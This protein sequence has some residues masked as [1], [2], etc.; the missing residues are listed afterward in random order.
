VRTSTLKKTLLNKAL[1][2]RTRLLKTV[3]TKTAIVACLALVGT[4]IGAVD[5]AVSARPLTKAP[6]V[7]VE[8]SIGGKDFA[9]RREAR[10]DPAMAS[11][12]SHHAHAE[13]P[14]PTSRLH[15]VLPSTGDG[16]TKVTGSPV[17]L[18]ALKA[19]AAESGVQPANDVGSADVEILPQTAARAAGVHGFIF[20]LSL[21]SSPISGAS[22]DPSPAA[23]GHST[24][25]ATAPTASPTD[26]AARTAPPSQS[27]T[28]DSTVQARA[29]VPVQVDYS[30]FAD[31]YGGDYASRLRLVVLPECA[32]ATPR[33]A[34]CPAPTPLATTRDAKTQTLR[35]T[36][37]V[38][39]SAADSATTT[40]GGATLL[41]VTST[42]GGDE[43]DFAATSLAPASEWSVGTQTGNFS[44]SYP[45][46]TVPV[47]GGL[48]PSVSVSYSSQ[49]IDGRTQASN[50]Q[51]SWLGEG[52]S[53]EP[54]YIERSYAACAD[55]QPAGEKTGD[56]CWKSANQNATM[57]FQGQSTQ[58]V[59]DKTTGEWRAKDDQGW[60]IRKLSDAPN[61]D[62]NGEYWEL[63]DQDGTRYYF[64]REKRFDADTELTRSAWTVPVY[65]DDPGE[66]CHASTFGQSR[67]AQVWRWNLDYVVDAHDN[68]IS[69]FYN[70]ET[71]RYGANLNNAQPSYV[72][73]GYLTRIDYGTV[74][75]Y[76]NSVLPA[77]RVA[78]TVAERCLPDADFDCDPS[79][80]N[81]TNAS[82]WPDVP[83]DQICTSDT[84]CP[85]VLSPTFF[86]RKRLVAVTTQVLSGGTFANVDQFDLTQSFPVAGD[87]S[88][89]SLYLNSIQRTGMNGG[90]ATT[91]P[92][93]FTAALMENRVMT[94]NTAPLNK[95]RVTG[96]TTETGSTITVNYSAKDCA[97]GDVPAE[98][99]TNTRRC[100]PV[101]YSLFGGDPTVNWFHKYVVDSVSEG[102]RA[103]TV[104]IS[105][106]YYTYSGGGAWHY[107]NNELV[108]KKYRTWGQ[109]R[110]YNTVE[111]RQGDPG[112]ADT[113]QSYDKYLYLRGMDGDQLPGGGTRS[114]T[115]TDS[116]GGTV[117]D[118]DRYNGFL[119][120]HIQKSGTTIVRAEINDPWSSDITANDSSDQAYIVRTGA[121]HVRKQFV[122]TPDLVK[123]TT[124]TDF[125]G[126]GLPT[127]VHDD[128]NDNDPND[129]TC[130][131]T[132]YAQN[133]AAWILTPVAKV[134]TVKVA[135]ST[136]VGSGDV[137]ASKRY[138][139]DNQPYSDTA[140][141]TRGEVTTEETL[142]GTGAGNWTV[143]KRSAYD[144]RGRAVTTTD[145]LG[146]T[147]A[148]AY[149]PAGTSAS[150]LGPVTATTS[151]NAKGQTSSTTLDPARGSAL[152]YTDLNGRVTSATYDA[153]GRRTAV[154]RPG[155]T[156]GVNSAD[157]KFDYSVSASTY[158]YVHTDRLLNDG[159]YTPSYTI[160]DAQLRTVE[161]QADSTGVT[162]GRV[163]TT[164]YFNSRGQ[165][166]H[167][168]G[169]FT[170]ANS[171]PSGTYYDPTVVQVMDNH[172]YLYDG[173]GR[174]TADIYQPKQ[175]ETTGGWRTTT[176]Y[177]ADKVSVDP[178]AG[179]TPTTTVS[180]VRGN[181]IQRIE[182]LSDGLSGT[183]QTTSYR[184]DLAGRMT[185]M[186]DPAGNQWT[187]DYD[188]AGNQISATD[189]DSGTTTTGYDAANQPTTTTSPAGSTFTSFDVLGRK[190]AL[191]EGTSAGPAKLRS[192]WTYDQ[193]RDGSAVPNGLGELTSATRYA[194][195]GGDTAPAYVQEVTGYEVHGQPTGT[196]TTIPSIDGETNGT[197][198]GTVAGTY[199]TSMTY[200]SD[201][202]LASKKLPT[203][204]GFTN[205]TLRFGYDRFGQPNGMGGT[206]S[207]VGGAKYSPYGELLQTTTGTTSGKLAYNS[208]FYDEGTRRLTRNMVSDQYV[209]G[210]ITDA[211]YTYDPA[212]NVLGIADNATSSS[213]TTKDLQCF[214]YDYQRQLTNA[215]TIAAG[216]TCGSPS[217][218]MLTVP[219]GY[220][221]SY[222][223]DAIGNRTTQTSY[224]QTGDTT[225]STYTY[226]ASGP[227]PTLDGDTGVGGPHAVASVSTQVGTGT[228]TSQDYLYDDSGQ[229][230]TR[231]SQ[232]LTWDPEGRLATTVN[233]AGAPA[234]KNVYDADGNRLLRK[235]PDGAVT[236]YLDSTEIRVATGTA[237][238]SSQRWYSFAGLTVATRTAAGL[239]LLSVDAHGTGQTQISAYNAAYTKR[240]FDPFGNLRT[241]TSVPTGSTWAGDHGFLEKPVDQTGLTQV[242]A[243]YYDTTI[244]KFISTDPILDTTNSI[245]TNAYA[246]AENNP[247]TM[248][249]PTGLAAKCV[250][251]GTCESKPNPA[252]GPP[253]PTGGI[254]PEPQN[255]G[256]TGVSRPPAG[257]STASGES[258]SDSGASG[259]APEDVESNFFVS[260]FTPI[261]LG[262]ST[263]YYQAAAD[264]NAIQLR[265]MAFMLRRSEMVPRSLAGILHLNP[266]KLDADAILKSGSKLTAASRTLGVVGTVASFAEYKKKDSTTAAVLK[267]GVETAAAYGFGAAGG[268]ACGA[269]SFG[270]AAP[271]CA[272][273]AG[274]LGAYAGRG[275]NKAFGSQ[276]DTAADS[277]D[278]GLRWTG[279]KLDAAGDTLGN[280]G[281][282]IGGWLD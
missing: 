142:H 90:T 7:Q 278:G 106:T 77:A 120:E 95:W 104:A 225:V 21:D 40:D 91:P 246:Y 103:G 162:A 222:G 10:T 197:G 65:G 206:Q 84:D 1:P 188:L 265:K 135:C 145:A 228:P 108:K 16:S 47:P 34:D 194:G 76:E 243:R 234:A 15:T 280:V 244:G 24:D 42:S 60:R 100:F 73:G 51:T 231:G 132:T 102:D 20:R 223:Y 175:D 117:A 163:I 121:T 237:T 232:T 37:P 276:I 161:T 168:V 154:W 141:P 186:T 116:Q 217:E 105:P 176:V 41:A 122:G 181:P 111:V 268:A 274:V 11:S 93:T 118:M 27:A 88:G 219:G 52:Q 245:Q 109:W 252:G 144:A 165:K 148:V 184:Y 136:S 18:G 216:S 115:V 193:A 49:S 241:P 240:R 79:K 67:C 133:T 140:I 19:P 192:S 269:V 266:T 53:L 3:V 209:S 202:S 282:A 83:F 4:G 196:R 99:S 281:S 226:P 207:L 58:L 152:S 61:G 59:K 9:P 114:V 38:N 190:T 6:K 247:V 149:T 146:N 55:S 33:G 183:T 177:D 182:Y 8:P 110:G 195:A 62:N 187:W 94:G 159:S 68:T 39:L 78:F 35:A 89:R 214:T 236:L 254:H 26:A 46:P 80:L 97:P 138:S 81:D 261:T 201:G 258:S 158:S 113:V 143:T 151:T 279:S 92:V 119:R 139:F 28:G 264:W 242:G 212:G 155:R 255:S 167:E 164:S 130:T 171:T 75:S 64:G 185:K 147:A 227:T 262:F 127:K 86:S 30:A 57:S 2:Q 251:E 5:G 126:N 178:P 256:P 98:E 205:E 123:S 70:E 221:T 218:A 180:D 36:A 239:Q 200:G 125:D 101:Y 263:G 229:M 173:A 213:G 270:A 260:L 131:R 273:G 199:T 150:T 189:P 179:G 215:W 13:L 74:A 45:I 166:V 56:L 275:F 112:E 208:W 82:H 191:Y 48:A 72:R 210:S 71:N 31:A 203:A 157:L 69:Y 233:T 14:A 12:K 259:S 235:D 249:D 204:P 230:R 267:A 29:Q 272:A 25:P 224:P 23:A 32:V 277:I 96:I 87:G 198:G 248:S 50:N 128:G 271:L 220:R 172:R 44:W 107:D 134:E 129:S 22:A 156:Q 238:A 85:D 153:L 253:I 160:L 257:H 250:L 211:N 170:V 17:A 66:P 54:G 169:P 174:Q 137:L 63:T 124:S 43:G